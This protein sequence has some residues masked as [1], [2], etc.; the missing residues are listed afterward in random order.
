MDDIFAARLMS[1]DLHTVSPDTLVEDAAEDMLTNDVGSLVV[2]DEEGGLE[3]ILTTTDFVGI[4]AE[5]H[6]KAETPVSRYMTTDV[7]TTTAGTPVGEVA[8]TIVDHG[9]HHVPVVDDAEGVIGMLST[10]DLTAYVSQ[11]QTPD[12]A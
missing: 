11:V 1:T 6:P 3:G 12:P 5:S 7:V 9:F 4:V 8:E 2:V 10:T